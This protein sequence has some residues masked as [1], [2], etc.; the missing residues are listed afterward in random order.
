MHHFQKI[1]SW[2]CLNGVA[3]LIRLLAVE[4]RDVGIECPLL[5]F[6]LIYKKK[7]TLLISVL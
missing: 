7:K 3:R 5:I 4:A 2:I 6:F 1:L